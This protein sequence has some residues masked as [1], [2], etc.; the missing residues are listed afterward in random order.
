MCFK[1]EEDN[2]KLNGTPLKILDQFTFIGS[3]ISSTKSDVNVHIEKMWI[4]IDRLSIIWKSLWVKRLYAISTSWQGWYIYI[5]TRMGWNVHIMVFTVNDFTN[6]IQ[7]LHY[8][9]IWHRLNLDTSSS[10]LMI[11]AWQSCDAG[12]VLIFL[13]DY[14]FSFFFLSESPVSQ[15]LLICGTLLSVKNKEGPSRLN[16]WSENR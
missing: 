2:S 12:F 8:R 13:I 3:N 16:N 14:F 11:G 7:V 9:F 4:T 5:H 6:E 1:H 10:D 15:F